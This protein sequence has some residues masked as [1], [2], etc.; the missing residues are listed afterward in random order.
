MLTGCATPKAPNLLDEQIATFEVSEAANQSQNDSSNNLEVPQTVQDK[1]AS[2]NFYMVSGNYCRNVTQDGVE[3]SEMFI[4][5]KNNFIRIA[6]NEMEQEVF[7]YNYIS[8]DFTYLYYFDGEL[9]SKTIFNVGT[10]AIIQDPE[11]Y[12]ELLTTEAEEIKI[13]FNDLLTTSGL[14]VNDLKALG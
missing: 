8:D 4:G 6:I 1:F 12:A 5:Y 13:Y 3:Y 9:L 2:I 14:N 11:D 10:G 7:A